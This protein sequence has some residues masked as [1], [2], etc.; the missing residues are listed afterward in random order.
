MFPRGSRHAPAGVI[1][2]FIVDDVDALAAGLAAGGVPV[3]TPV[4]DE[5]W[6]QRHTYV[7]D[8]SGTLVDVVQVTTPDPGWLAANV[9]ASAG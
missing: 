8:P 6:G 1:V 4:R 7:T 9:P 2:A 3:V 5:P